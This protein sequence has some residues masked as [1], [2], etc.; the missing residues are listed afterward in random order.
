MLEQHRF[1]T[2][3]G[4]LFRTGDEDSDVPEIS[5]FYGIVITMYWPDHPPPH[6][7]ARYAS[8]RAKIAIGTGALLAGALPPRALGLVRQWEAMHRDDLQAN[9]ERA[10]ANERL[11]RIDPLP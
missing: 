9:W 7:H 8:E 10:R 11:V 1:V 6:F 4:L 3:F 5:R 2:Q